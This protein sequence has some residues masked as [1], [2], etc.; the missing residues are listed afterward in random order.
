MKIGKKQGWMIGGGV[1]G[2]AIAGGA[3]LHIR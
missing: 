2:A 3:G 1:A